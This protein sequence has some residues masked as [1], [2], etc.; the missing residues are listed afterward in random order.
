MDRIV[1]TNKDMRVA[2]LSYGAITQGW[3]L[4]ETPLILGHDDP[5]DYRR[6]KNFL[7]AI[8]GRTANRIA[9]AAFD[10]DGE[11]HR[12]LPNEGENSLHGGPTGTWGQDWTI[13]EAND[14][15]AHLK[16]HSPE[17]D[18][19]YPGAVDFELIVTLDAPR[20]IYDLRATVSRPTPISLAQHNY[21]CLGNWPDTQGHT[22]TVKAAETLDIDAALIPS[23]ILAP[24]AG[25]P[26][27]FRTPAPLSQARDGVDHFYVLDPN[28]DTSKPSVTL[29][30]PDGLSLAV[31][32][33]EPGTQVYTGHAISGPF[34][35]CAGVCIEPS[36]FPNAVNIPA[37]PSVIATPERPY[38]QVLT[39]TIEQT[40][41]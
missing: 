29:T 20:L 5:E 17:G 7:G 40:A 33:E 26:L 2:L 15:T 25:T 1:L 30:A 23:G 38:R 9:G 27:D 16:L 35:K 4:G 14:T 28:R 41:P 24:V 37:F 36:G 3:W 22:L 8:A 32:T 12:L 21:Y 18:G 34:A 10:L 19:G 6:D 11:T 13:A 39:L 31:T